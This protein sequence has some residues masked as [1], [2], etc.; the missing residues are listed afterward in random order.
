MKKIVS[1]FALC[2]S[3]LCSC[4]VSETPSQKQY[5]ETFLSLFDTVTTIT[6][7]ANSE[8]DF[9][10]VILPI[11]DEM[12][13][14]HQLFDIYNEYDGLNNLKTIN[15]HAAISPVVAD[16]AIL[17]LLEDC[18]YY[19]TVTDG[20]FNPAMGSV[21]SL[22]HE[23]REYGTDNPDD[24]Y[25]PDTD[26]LKAAAVHTNP[27]DIIIDRENSTVFFA[28]PLLRLDVGGIA[29]GWA[30]QRICKNAPEGLLINVGGNI[31][32]T[33][34][35]NSSG[36]PWVI[37]IQNPSG[38]SSYLHILN[39]TGGSVV[40]SGSYHRTYTV[41]GRQY[42]HIID[43]TTL[44]PGELWTSVSVVCEDSEIADVL[45]TSLFLLNREKGQILLD[46]FNAEALWVDTLG[47]KYYS[48]G[49]KS[50]ILN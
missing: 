36:A 33:G 13:Y 32:A 35:K 48:N 19:Y 40:T 10:S 23:A 6:G 49:F 11:R 22:W 37:G 15:E 4:A 44:Y 9:R 3:V 39:I 27:K 50:F 41:N 34:P 16:T 42:H 25:I 12:E 28:D 47:E 7:E 5:T 18:K 46:Q 20:I 17:D 38:E 1:I 31:Y 2:L 29:K 21:L 45:S 8:E 14:Y 26:A 30:V 43:P 24:S